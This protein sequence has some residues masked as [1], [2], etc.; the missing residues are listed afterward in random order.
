MLHRHTITSHAAARRQKLAEGGRVADE[1]DIK[2]RQLAAKERD[3]APE[4]GGG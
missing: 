1:A 4:S 2:A 3:R